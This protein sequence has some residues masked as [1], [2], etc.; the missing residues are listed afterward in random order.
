[1]RFLPQP[2][3]GALRL[4]VSQNPGHVLRQL[5]GRFCVLR[6]GGLLLPRLKR[7]ANQRPVDPLVRDHECVRAGE[8]Y[9]LYFFLSEI[10]PTAGE[11]P[12]QLYLCL[13]LLKLAMCD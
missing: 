9:W 3:I 7:E 4:D 6:Y 2:Q 8:V 11:R 1:M 10:C 13:Y 5:G 12:T